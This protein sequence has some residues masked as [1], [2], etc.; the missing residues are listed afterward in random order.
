MARICVNR[1]WFEQVEPSTFS[2]ET[3]E[4]RVA[5]HAPSVYPFFHVVP[6]KKPVLAPDNSEDRVTHVAPDLAFI[7]KDYSEWW[8]VEVEMGYHSFTGHVK[9][10]IEK[11]LAADYGIDEVDYLCKKY[12]NLNRNK[13]I[14]LITGTPSRV[15]VILNQNRPDWASH[16]NKQTER[17]IV[18]VF[19]LFASQDNKEIFRVDG[20]YPSI[21]S[22]RITKCTYHPSVPRLLGVE[23]PEKLNLP[24][25]A[26][27]KMLYNNCVTEWRRIDEGE[28][29]WLTAANRNPLR[30]KSN[31]AIYRQNDDQ[32]VLYEAHDNAAIED[33]LGETDE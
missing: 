28:Q 24:R 31:Y 11:L 4:E 27:I 15:L 3:F 19:E 10:Q 18:A 29:V 12:T 23:E 8:I 14:S 2:E 9:P 21:L 33:I 7:A 5:L 1:E 13:L 25:R 16:W 32:F 17:V 22:D 6:F 30:P 20:A 26:I